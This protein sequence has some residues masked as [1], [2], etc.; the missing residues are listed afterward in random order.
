MA[1][2]FAAAALGSGERV[3]CFRRSGIFH[4]DDWEPEE[5]QKRQLGMMGN[6]EGKRRG[7]QTG[8]DRRGKD[9]QVTRCGEGM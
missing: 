3:V 4:G 1:D 8:D 6:I 9:G 5:L 2:W 7:G